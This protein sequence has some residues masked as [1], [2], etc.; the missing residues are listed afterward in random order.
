MMRCPRWPQILSYFNLGLSVAADI[1]IDWLLD[2]VGDA[3]S[4]RRRWG[5]EIKNAFPNFLLQSGSMIELVKLVEIIPGDIS[6]TLRCASLMI[7]T[8]FLVVA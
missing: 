1:N 4:D 8:A 6:V 3:T 5:R 7:R 2:C